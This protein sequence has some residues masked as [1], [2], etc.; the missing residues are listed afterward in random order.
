MLK[1]LKGMEVALIFWLAR[2]VKLAM[3]GLFIASYSRVFFGDETKIQKWRSMDKEEQVKKYD[4]H[5]KF[6]FCAIL[7]G[8][9]AVGMIIHIDFTGKGSDYERSS[10]NSSKFLRSFSV[11]I[12]YSE[13]VVGDPCFQ[14][15]GSLT[16][17]FMINHR[18][19]VQLSHYV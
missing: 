16:C 19:W 5:Q 2:T 12:G 13:Q 11:F 17:L 10:F 18:I 7:V 14:R 15:G 8:V 3:P 4:G 6:R 1:A 9:D